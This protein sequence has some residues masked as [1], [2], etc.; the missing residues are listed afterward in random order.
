MFLSRLYPLQNLWFMATFESMRTCFLLLDLK[1]PWGNAKRG[2]YSSDST[3]HVRDACW[4]I[5]M[6]HLQ[7]PFFRSFMARLTQ[8]H[9]IG[10]MWLLQYPLHIDQP[11]IFSRRRLTE[12]RQALQLVILQW[13]T[14]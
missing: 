7:P 4:Y 12:K 2:V 13:A 10:P 9:S 6:D 11:L 3:R 14:W 1:I 8:S 5:A